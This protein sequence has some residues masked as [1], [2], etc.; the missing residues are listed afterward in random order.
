MA[1]IT[2]V[3]ALKGLKKFIEEKV[4][5]QMMLPKELT[6]PVEYVH[7]YVSLITLP[8]KN[9][10][11]INFQVPHILIGLTDGSEDASEGRLSIRIAC[12][13]YTGDIQ[14]KDEANIPDD[15][16]YIDML[17]ML[18][19]I[20]SEL[21]HAGVIEGVCRVDREMS[22][23]IYDE[24][25]TYPY[26]YGYLSFNVDIPTVVGQFDVHDYL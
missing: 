16:G 3:Y 26:W 20:K 2:A 1:G 13:T 19:R 25:L 18:E 7:P 12:A 22:Y 10:M 4:A 24:Q 5:S 9:F 8:H 15:T 11:P 14:F 23:G 17:N 21:V 6:N